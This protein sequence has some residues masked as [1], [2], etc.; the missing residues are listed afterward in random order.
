MKVEFARAGDE[1]QV[2]A[3]TAEWDGHGV[4]I[5]SQDESLR[6]A[7]A[8]A[9]RHTPVLVADDASYR[10]LGTSGEVVIAPGDL[11]WFRAVASVRAP[12][13]AGVTARFVPGVTGGY[14]PAANYRT[15][16]EQ[17]EI[18]DERSRGA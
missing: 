7:L 3:A 6:I 2:T 11:E 4:T 18:L 9:F 17:L 13:E 8:H 10:R 5:T 14:D 15:F 1:A 16:Q 12:T